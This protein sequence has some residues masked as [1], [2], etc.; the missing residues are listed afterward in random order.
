MLVENED[1]HFTEAEPTTVGATSKPAAAP[2][3]GGVVLPRSARQP[4]SDESGARTRVQGVGESGRV[5]RQP[6]GPDTYASSPAAPQPYGQARAQAEGA[7]NSADHQPAMASRGAVVNP[8][9]TMTN[10]PEHYEHVSSVPRLAVKAPFANALT[11]LWIN[12]TDPDE[13]VEFT[14]THYTTFYQDSRL[15]QEA[16]TVHPPLPG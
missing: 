16:M 3:G 11:G 10:T 2:T 1:G 15:F 6:G 8:N 14:P 12:T 5:N 7:Y 13:I 4:T 9:T